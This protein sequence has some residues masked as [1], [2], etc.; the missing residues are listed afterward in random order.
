MIALDAF[1]KS[2]LRALSHDGRMTHTALSETVNLSPNAV[3][4]RIKRLQRDGVI[5][6]F[7]VRLSAKALGK[8][9][10]V[11]IEVKLDR[12]SADVF[13]AFSAAAAK[14]SE[15]EECHMVAGGFD[16]LIKTRHADM[17]AFRRFLSDTLLSLPGIRETH[18]YAV[19]E[20]VKASATTV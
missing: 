1:D 7:G 12:T 6:G 18:T 20:E 15:I 11:F 10:L 2:I 9:L 14:T 5:E 13:D 8:T 4:E 3:A 19:M 16:Y 17:A